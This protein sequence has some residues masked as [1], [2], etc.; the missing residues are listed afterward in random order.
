MKPTVHSY[1][2]GK[3]QCTSPNSGRE[4]QKF[5]TRKKRSEPRDRERGRGET[6]KKKRTWGRPHGSR[7]AMAS[8]SALSWS[9]S[10]CSWTG[11]LVGGLRRKSP[12]PADTGRATPIVAQ[13]KAKKIRKV[14]RLP[15]LLARFAISCSMIVGLWSINW[16]PI[17]PRLFSR[18]TSRSWGRRGSSWM[19]KPGSFATTFSPRGRPSSSLLSF[20]SSLLCAL[21]LSVFLDSWVWPL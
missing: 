18:R 12:N 3:Q 7:Q 1:C 14:S 15:P 20:S 13:K 10:C 4:V 5:W 8:T 19:W 16:T 2:N 17:V 6:D 21:V 9:S 11:S